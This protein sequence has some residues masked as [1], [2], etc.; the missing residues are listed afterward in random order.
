MADK[1]YLV[2]HGLKFKDSLRSYSENVALDNQITDQQAIKE[3]IEELLLYDDELNNE[4]FVLNK[5]DENQRAERR[6]YVRAA[7]MQK[8][9][10]NSMADDLESEPVMLQKPITFMIIDISMGGIGVISDY[11]LEVGKVL[12]FKIKFDHFS[13]DIRCQVVYCFEHEGKYR[14]GLKLVKGDK[15]FIKH[16]KIMVARI[17]LQNKYDVQK[18]EK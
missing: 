6:R 7:Y 1:R 17:T 16:L 9:E 5:L 8:I 2:E 10:C 11:E 12:A 4:R 14:A 3:A 18:D 15:Q 13:Y